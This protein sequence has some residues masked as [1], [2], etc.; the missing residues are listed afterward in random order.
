MTC[1]TL[2]KLSKYKSNFQKRL[3]G[4]RNLFEFRPKKRLTEITDSSIM[5][6][7]IKYATDSWL[8]MWLWPPVIQQELDKFRYQ[9]NNRR[10]RK[11]K[12]KT[13]PSGVS[14]N[15]AY[16]FPERYGGA[17]CLQT[18]DVRVIQDI[19]DQMQAEKDALTDWGVP[20]DF[21]RRARTA[22]EEMCAPEI[23]ISNIW[24][25]FQ[26]ILLRL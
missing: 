7:A 22:F 15:I 16:T 20:E 5:Q 1:N 12:Q 9:A 25:V 4:L 8:A 17:D 13:L 11:Q 3:Q 10:V 6:P 19:L 18:V 26:C 23:S 2:E 21:S 24:I 14:P